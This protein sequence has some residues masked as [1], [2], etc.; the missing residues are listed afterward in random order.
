MNSGW[1]TIEQKTAGVPTGLTCSESTTNADFASGTVNWVGYIATSATTPAGLSCKYLYFD[2]QVGGNLSIQNVAC[3]ANETYFSTP[4][5]GTGQVLFNS[6]TNLDMRVMA[7][8]YQCFVFVNNCSGADTNAFWCMGVPYV[9]ANIVGLAVSGVVASGG[10]IKITTSTAHGLTT[11]EL[12]AARGIGGVTAAN[13]TNNAITVV[14]TTSFTLDGS[15][16]A[17]AYTSGGFVGVSSIGQTNFKV[18]EAIW[19]SGT[20]S[21]NNFIRRSLYSGGNTF[22]TL[23]NGSVQ[24][25]TGGSGS[26]SLATI[27][28]NISTTVELLWGN[29]SAL[30]TEPFICFGTSGTSIGPIVGQT[31]NSLIMRKL[32]T[33][34]Q[35]GPI[36]GH[37]YWNMTDNFVGNGTLGCFLYAV[38]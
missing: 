22:W 12:V 30:V 34:D 9:P 28:F 6:Y 27:I 31:W 15:T 29:G 21:S 25:D 11:G 32:A 38:A 2:A 24:N 3:D 23:L 35:S 36:D 37:T 14:D 13:V 20:S 1:L 19:Q 26:L 10:L 18:V 8:K 17:G 7:D 33:R 16:F 5:T 4:T